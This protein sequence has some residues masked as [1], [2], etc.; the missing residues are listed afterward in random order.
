M[1][2]KKYIKILVLAGAMM[3]LSACGNLKNSDLS[4]NS[5]TTTTKTK[6][7]QT[8]G[9][10]SNGYTVLL[11]NG[12]YLTSEISGLTA[13]DNDNSVDEREFQRGLV[14]ISEKVYSPKNYVFQEGQ[15]L[16]STTVSNWLGRYSKSN[17]TGLNP[18]N[19]GK[20]GTNTRNPVRLE[21]I[22]END[23]LT[24]SGQSYKLAG[25]S[26]GMAMNSTD[27]YQK[28][29]NGATYETSISKAEQLSY[30]KQY[31][32]TI[33][34]R[35]R[36][37]KKLKHIPITIGIF[38]K[39]DKN[40]LVGGTFIAYGTASANSSKITKWTTVSQKWQVLPTV[41]DESAYNSS[42]ETSFSNFKSAVQNYFPNVS[43]IIG[44][45]RY[46][47]KK[48]VQEN[49]QI[50]TQFYGYEQVK[51][52]AQLVQQD[53]KKYLSAAPAVEITIATANDTEAVVYKDTSSSTYHV[54]IYGG[55]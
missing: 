36:A 47:D 33:I 28:T 31:A 46:E 38:S 3:T 5:T 26:L 49:I 20:T 7:Y 14:E 24:G 30:G 51:S 54:H 19:N 41:D 50:T 17:K 21:E 48:L 25:M 53:A 52:F 18:K 40:S 11:K 37:K 45:L 43:G 9:T 42:D 22:E 16:D 39:T 4:S 27:Y 35:L 13:T 29:T 55:E 44:K 12:K 10:D 34:K 32:N 2:V 8:T 15:Y 6:R 1:I 23:F